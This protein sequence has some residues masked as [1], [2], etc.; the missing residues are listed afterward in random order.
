MLDDPLTIFPRIFTKLKTCWI[1]ATYPFANFGKRVSV[2]YSCEIER[3]GARFVHLGDDVRLAAGVWLNMVPATEDTGLKI[4][5]EKGC[6]I[7]RRC[8][9]SARNSISLGEDVLL[10]P[11]VLIMDHNHEYSNPEIAIVNQPATPGGRI[12]IGKNCWLG[13]G[14]VI[15][16][17]SGELT[18]GRNSVVGANAVVTKSFPPF[19][20]IA[21]NPGRLIK[22]YDP[23]LARWIRADSESVA[24][25]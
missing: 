20:V 14:A 10:G 11:S 12:E 7:G 22:R 21:G 17:G 19:S 4:R 24:S 3:P 9:I 1:K 8:S 5:L 2:H 23:N 15:F 18:I 16:C 13:Y 25:D 6:K